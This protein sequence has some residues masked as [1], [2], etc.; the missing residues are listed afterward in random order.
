MQKMHHVFGNAYI[1]LST[2]AKAN[3]ERYSPVQIVGLR[4]N[5]SEEDMKVCQ[6]A[7]DVAH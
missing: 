2:C 5:K 1:A 3:A 6:F 4:K 7:S